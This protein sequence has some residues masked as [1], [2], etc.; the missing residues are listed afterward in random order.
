[1]TFADDGHGLLS[2]FVSEGR[3][4]MC[5]TP[6]FFPECLFSF[7]SQSGSTRSLHLGCSRGP[8]LVV[9]IIGS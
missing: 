6:H 2:V 5:L 8:L 4:V 7:K 9:E 3:R 1:M